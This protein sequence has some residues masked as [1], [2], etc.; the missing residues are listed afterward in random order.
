MGNCLGKTSQSEAKPVVEV[1]KE[2]EPTPKEATPLFSQPVNSTTK[3]EIILDHPFPEMK[4][5]ELSDV[6]VLGRELGR[7]EFG[8]TFLATNRGTGEQV[9]C[10]SIPKRKLRT[11]IDIDDVRREVAI[12]HHLPPHP[13]I[14]GLK[15]VFEDKH[16]VH[17][18]QELCEG[19]ELFERI[20]ARGHYSERQAAEITRTIV[21]VVQ[22]C[23]TN[24]VMHRD[25]KPENF[26][27]ASKQEDSSLRA[28]DFG[29]S[30]MF[31]PGEVFSEIVGSPY[32]MA[33]EVLRK[34]YGPQADVW[35][36]GVILYILLCGVPPFWA[37]TEQGVAQ[38]VLRSVVDLVRDPWPKISDSAK[39]LVMSMLQP[40][41]KKRPTAAQVLSHPWLRNANEA[42]DTPLG[43]IVLSRMK[44]FE[45]ANKLKKLAL[46][47]IADQMTEEEV[48]GLQEVFKIIDADGSGSIT[49]DELRTGLQQIGTNL[50]ET[51]VRSL[52]EATD[53]DG[54]GLID[55]PEFVAATM[56]IQ[57]VDNEQNLRAAFEYFDSDHSGFIDVEE[58][59]A[60]LGADLIALKEVLA[61]VDT[62]MDG[63]I[64]FEEFSS[65]MRKG[66]TMEMKSGRRN[67]TES[68]STFRSLLKLSD[69]DL[70]PADQ[71]S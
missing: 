5:K 24:G 22:A 20:I 68:R 4:V 64:S 69:L 48:Q 30:V 13:N 8:V 65:M 36:A 25:L 38:A 71:Q 60:A 26:L 67:L 52:L 29:L 9:A 55:Y 66:M 53:I 32:Y 35:S 28:I 56:H 23:H 39:D 57:R 54:N 27:F 51:E 34:N 45:A 19:G 12:M 62:N 15:G 2:S 14:V 63:K 18:V 59:A 44:Q 49:L 70:S 46:K 41:V 16:A 50:S 58:L 47:F 7:G 43:A 42:P 31:K 1:K 3:A 17:I 11:A 61:E 10:K 33:P 21:E 40:D 6:Y 37:E